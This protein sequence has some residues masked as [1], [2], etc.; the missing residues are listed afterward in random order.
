MSVLVEKKPKLEGLFEGSK[1]ITRVGRPT[2]K[3]DFGKGVEVYSEKTVTF[4]LNKEKT[5]W[6]TFPSV[7][8][9]KG[10]ISSED[11]VRKY[12]LKNGPIE[13]IT[14]EKFPIHDSV[15]KA[16]KYAKKRSDSLLKNNQGG[17]VLKALK[18]KQA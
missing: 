5:K 6:V 11:E 8:D 10:T 3:K 15:E 1:V 9:K 17:K 12:V 13:A 4:P 7:L 2:Y 14:G 16:E 18:R